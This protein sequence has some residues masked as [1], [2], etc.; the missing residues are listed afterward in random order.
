LAVF[1]NWTIAF[2]LWI[3]L[4]A[5]FIIIFFNGDQWYRSP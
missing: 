4:H 1:S 3:K 2:L 5:P